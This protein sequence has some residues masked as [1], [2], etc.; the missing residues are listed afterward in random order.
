MSIARDEDEGQSQDGAG[1]SKASSQYAFVL[2]DTPRSGRTSEEYS[3][4]KGCSEDDS[5]D[6]ADTPRNENLRNFDKGQPSPRKP[7]K[8]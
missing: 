3:S 2:K 5:F 1:E 4:H 6:N 8:R 7:Q